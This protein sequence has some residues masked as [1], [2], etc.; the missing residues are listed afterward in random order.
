MT[1]LFNFNYFLN[2]GLR[3]RRG[4]RW[5]R[6]LRICSGVLRSV[7]NFTLKFSQAGPFWSNFFSRPA[8]PEDLQHR[9]CGRLQTPLVLVAV[10]RFARDVILHR[11]TEGNGEIG[12][13]EAVGLFVVDAI[14]PGE[15]KM[16]DHI[17]GLSDCVGV[18]PQ[19]FRTNSWRVKAG[20]VA[21][22]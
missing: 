20:L 15:V 21:R 2:R 13:A 10:G 8:R 5:S 1:I 18:G 16:G 14:K 4:H 11:A 12:T 19:I 9:S 7:V 6:R 17:R 22:L 3:T